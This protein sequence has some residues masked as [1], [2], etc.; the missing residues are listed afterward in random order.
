MVF[1]TAMPSTIGDSFTSHDEEATIRQR[2]H[3][4]LDDVWNDE[5]NLNAIRYRQSRAA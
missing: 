2:L 1:E 3:V 5:A 4:P